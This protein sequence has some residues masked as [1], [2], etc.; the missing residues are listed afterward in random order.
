MI[1]FKK[2]YR[3]VAS[4]FDFVHGK[5]YF[6]TFNSEIQIVN[7]LAFQAAFLTISNSSLACRIS[8]APIRCRL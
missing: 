3:K 4:R 2:K 6:Y 7:A 5:A 8:S 1:F